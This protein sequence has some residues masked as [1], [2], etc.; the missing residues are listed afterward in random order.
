MI[1]RNFLIYLIKL[2]HRSKLK[3]WGIMLIVLGCLAFIGIVVFF[4]LRSYKKKKEE[5]P[6]RRKEGLNVQTS[7]A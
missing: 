7:E 6:L 3:W 5:L 2:L 4:V 1:K